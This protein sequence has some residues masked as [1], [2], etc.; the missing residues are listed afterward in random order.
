M[1]TAGTQSVEFESVGLNDKAVLRCN[2]FLQSLDLAILELH[3]GA[4]AGTDEVVVMAFMGDVIVLRLGTE[5][6]GLS[7]SGFTEQIERP[8]NSS[9]A[10]VRVFFCELVIHGFRR[11]VFLAKKGRQNQL[12]LAG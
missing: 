11:D 1:P 2:L 10:Q 8:V 3:N 6:T 5:V 12:A 4:T 7:N 9:Q